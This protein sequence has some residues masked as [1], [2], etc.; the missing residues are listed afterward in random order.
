M[1]NKLKDIFSNKDETYESKLKFKDN[2]AYRNFLA[3][4]DTV[5]KDGSTIVVEGIESISLFLQDHGIK[6]PMEQATNVSKF[7]VG[8]SI[9]QVEFP[10]SWDSGDK[11]FK[12]KRYRITE[13]TVLETS[14]NN[15]VYL[16]LIFS[17]STEKIKMTYKI[18]YQHAKNVEEIAFELK[19]FIYLFKKFRT[20]AV[21]DNEY[22]DVKKIKK[23]L[24]SLKYAEEFIERVLSLENKIGVSFET[25]KMETMTADDQTDVEELYLLLCEKTP[26]R[27]NAKFETTNAKLEVSDIQKEIQIGAK[28]AAV[29]HREVTYNLFGQEFTIYSIN[30][31]FNAIIKD[32]KN[33]GDITHIYYGDT[34]IEPMYMS[35]LA[36][37]SEDE[38]KLESRK[39]ICNS[40]KYINA[41]TT[42]E[43]IEKRLK[44]LQKSTQ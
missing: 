15:V 13:G 38:A 18:N 37:L 39:K 8:P 40:P 5:E 43:H 41:I 23:L 42:A 17:Q 2:D 31:L 24:L 28:I 21:S 22:D 10:V 27:L 16:K 30:A 7:M 29:F 32:Y 11:V 34:D 6:F 20:T 4:L 44:A 19:A 12:F 14:K 9:E 1:S 3:A 35:Y 36:F 26:L 33:D 25:K